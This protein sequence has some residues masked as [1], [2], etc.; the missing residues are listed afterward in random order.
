MRNVPLMLT[1]VA[2]VAC[3][4]QVT[5]PAA[6][7]PSGEARHIEYVIDQ[8]PPPPLDTGVVAYN[9][10]SGFGQLNVTYFL[11]TQGT[12]GWLKFNGAQ[13]AGTT[14][15]P[16]AK[17]TMK[18]GVYSGV[19]TVSYLAQAGTVTIDLSSISRASTFANC[20]KG[21]FTARF[22]RATVTSAGGTTTALTTGVSVRPAFRRGDEVVIT[23]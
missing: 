8:P 10:E 15:T 13:P 4:D 21:C 18:K 22:D 23:Q 6:L 20:A 11:N 14:A 16:S 12:Y 19:G 1:L 3:R 5:A 9:A 2:L 7:L 17:V